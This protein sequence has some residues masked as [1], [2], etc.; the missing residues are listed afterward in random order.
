MKELTKEEL[1]EFIRGF[2]KITL[3]DACKKAKVNYRN[4]FKG[5][6]SRD[7]LEKIKNLLEEE[8]DNLYKDNYL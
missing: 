3:K 1:L 5:E 8:I 6:V 2:T 4:L 7:N